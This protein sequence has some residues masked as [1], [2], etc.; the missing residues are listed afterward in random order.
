MSG[1]VYATM[2]AVYTTASP[3]F[4]VYAN[5]ACSGKSYASASGNTCMQKGSGSY[6]TATC[7][8][9]QLSAITYASTDCTGAG[10][11]QAAASAMSTC[12]ANPGMPGQYS[13]ISCSGAPLYYDYTEK[14]YAGAGCTGEP[15][16]TVYGQAG[17][18]TVTGGNGYS[19]F[20]VQCVGTSVTGGQSLT[21][22]KF[23]STDCSG[24]QLSAMSQTISASGNCVAVPDPTA[25]TI[26]MKVNCGGPDIKDA[27]LTFVNGLTAGQIAGIVIGVLLGVGLIGYVLYRFC[28]APKQQGVLMEGDRGYDHYAKMVVN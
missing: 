15:A 16:S 20:N 17:C 28:C 3:Y 1:G 18:V 27:I 4:L 6:S 24:T 9:G 8:S 26:Y 22:N 25:G 13:Q 23:T 2:A 19:S 21:M 11:Q 7:I 10:I 14:I 12:N 5:P